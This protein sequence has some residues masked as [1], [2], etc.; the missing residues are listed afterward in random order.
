MKDFV[1]INQSYK[2]VTSSCWVILLQYGAFVA[3]LFGIKLW[4]IGFY[5]NATPYWDQW[6]AEAAD[7][8]KPFLEGALHWTDLFA[9]HNEHRIFTTRLLALA[10]LSINGVWNPLL[11]MVVN[12]GLHIVALVISIALLTRVIGRNHLPALL[13]FAL[14]MFGVPYA[15]ENTLAGFQSQFY[16]VLL[17][18]MLFLWCAV[19]QEPLSAL[20]WGGV[21]CGMFA[22]LSL[23]SGIFAFATAAIV[24]FVF[25]AVGLRKT[26]KQLL[27]VAIL[28]G[29]FML[30]AALTPSVAGH[31]SLKATSFLQFL[32]ASTATLGWPIFANFLSAIIRNFPALIF[33]GFMLWK[34]PPANDR[35]WF[36]LALV[37]WALGPAASIA[38]GRAVGNLS[39]RYLD[40]FAIAILVNFACLIEIAQEYIGQRRGWRIAAVGVWTA[41][42][43]VSLGLYAIKHIPADLVAKRDTGL[44]QEINTRNY[45]ATGDFSHLQNK[46]FLHVPYPNSERLAS[47]LA[48]PD[49]R[50]ILPTNISRPLTPTSIEIK[51]ANA[52]VA[53]GYYPTPPQRTD[54]TLG[55]YSAQGDAAIGQ[56]S[57]RFDS[58]V[59]SGLVAIPVAGYPLNSGIKLEIEQ[60]GQRNSVV[61]KINPKESWVMAYAMVGSGAFSIHLTDASTLTWL[62]VGAPIVAGRLDE[63]INILLANHAVFVMVGLVVGVLLMTVDGLANGDKVRRTARGE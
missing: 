53:N 15:W 1:E 9:P 49:I 4:L 48:S 6:D 56:A 14:A 61:M 27:A 38:Y 58:N 34:R 30:G 35:K 10:E 2:A 20:W 36:L 33:S 18:S 59:R 55:S 23:A 28:A 43:L 22:F 41:T 3:M 46:P 17:F 13:V 24:G 50:A 8:Y 31:A 32:N 57:V 54:M 26:R 47:I 52:F 11:Q 21:V 37:V 29:L 51:P 42:V 5:G 60:D 12:A 25:Y 39:S 63:L 19:T 45:L 44:A 62:A 16:F 40:L 7:L